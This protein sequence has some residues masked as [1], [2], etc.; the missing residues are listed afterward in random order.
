MCLKSKTPR[1]HIGTNNDFERNSKL[2]FTSVWYNIC[3]CEPRLMRGGATHPASAHRSARGAICAAVLAS[4]LADTAGLE[5]RKEIIDVSQS[6]LLRLL[7][8][9]WRVRN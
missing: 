7:S 8:A 6:N 2:Q 3:S 5:Y 1:N 9:R 4:E